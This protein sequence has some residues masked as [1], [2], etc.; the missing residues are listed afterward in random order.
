MNRLLRAFI[1]APASDGLT[2][3]E[4]V[5]DVEN[6]EARLATELSLQE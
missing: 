4:A 3:L 5:Q 1:R 2:A 6:E